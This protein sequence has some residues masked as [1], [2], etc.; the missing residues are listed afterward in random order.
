LI[1]AGLAAAGVAGFLAQRQRRR[2]RR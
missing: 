1:A 2:R